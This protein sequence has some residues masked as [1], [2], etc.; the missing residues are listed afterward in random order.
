[1]CKII[2]VISVTFDQIIAP[3]HFKNESMSQSGP[4]TVWLLTFFK[5]SSVRKKLIQVWNNKGVS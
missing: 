4:S 5:M 3:W 1:L 2:K